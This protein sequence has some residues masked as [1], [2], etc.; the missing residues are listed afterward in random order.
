MFIAGASQ[1]EM[2]FSFTSR[3]AARPTSF[4]SFGFQVEASIV[5]QGH[6]VVYT[7]HSGA[8]RS[9][10]GPSAV[11]TFGTPYSGRLPNPNVLATPVFGCPPSSS[12]R[13]LSDSCAKN[14]SRVTCPSATS[15]SFVLRISWENTWYLSSWRTIGAMP[16]VSSSLQPSPFSI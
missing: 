14:S 13:S 3:A 10:A 7:P 2:L 11:I 9:P 8:M 1:T 5:A 4:T 16:S 6:A 15:S 12:T